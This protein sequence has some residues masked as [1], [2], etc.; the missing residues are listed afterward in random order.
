MA[1][2]LSNVPCF[3]N[4]C[5]TK[6]KFEENDYNLTFTMDSYIAEVDPNQAHTTLIFTLK[7]EAG[8]LAET[9]KIFKLK[10]L[11][12]THIE[13]R[14]SKVHPGC[15]EFM[16]ECAEDSNPESLEEVIALFRR[17]AESAGLHKPRVHDHNSQIRQNKESIPWFPMKISD[18][19]YF[20]NRVLSYGAELDSDHPGFH[21]EIYKVRRKEFAD[22]AASFRYG[23]KIP[24]VEY[25]QEE[26]G[27]WKK[28]IMN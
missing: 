3:I 23:D 15:Y 25:T 8:A 14:P 18:I 21:D 1:T 2:A 12:L 6:T 5:E 4:D 26:I 22:I 13:S 9:L 24:Q 10:N 11:N 20:A 19:D 27:T 7:E 28:Y 16:V 17:R